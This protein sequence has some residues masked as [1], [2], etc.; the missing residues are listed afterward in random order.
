M[1]LALGPL[2]IRTAAQMP[3][4]RPSL[5]WVIQVLDKVRLSSNPISEIRSLIMLLEKVAVAV[6]YIRR[7]VISYGFLFLTVPETSV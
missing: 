5:S 2:R 6:Q 3:E 1:E 4:T 7:A